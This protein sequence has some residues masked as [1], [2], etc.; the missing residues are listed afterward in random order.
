M[1]L[2]RSLTPLHTRSLA[3]PLA[4]SLTPS[5]NPTHRPR[6]H[7]QNNPPP[8]LRPHP[9]NPPRERRRPHRRPHRHRPG[10]LRRNGL[11]RNNARI[12]N[13]T[14][15]PA[16]PIRQVRNRLQVL[17]GASIDLA[18]AERV[19]QGPF[20][21][22]ARRVGEA[23]APAAG[24]GLLLARGAA[25]G[26]VVR[27]GGVLAGDGGIGGGGGGGD[28]D[29]DGGGGEAAVGVERPAELFRERLRGAVF[30]GR[31]ADF[32]AAGGGGAVGGGALAG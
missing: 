26:V 15:R 32:L 3:Y 18:R 22:D 13:T 27:V 17:A 8:H 12:T 11:I 5:H 16:Q 25:R 4:H 10:R 31:A 24:E 19:V 29:G 23:A 7:R 6:H 20:A 30:G 2:I 9:R 28:C 21:T 1:E 14:L